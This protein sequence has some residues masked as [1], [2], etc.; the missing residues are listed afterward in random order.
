MVVCGQVI[1]VGC[2][3]VQGDKFDEGMVLKIG[4]QG[5]VCLCCGDGFMLVFG[6]NLSLIIEKYEVGF[7]DKC[8][9]VK[10][11]LESGLLGQKV[12]V[13]IV[14]FWEV[15]MFIVVMVVCGIE[16]IVEINSE[17]QI[18][19]NVQFGQVDVEVLLVFMCV[20][21]LCKFSCV[22][23]DSLKVG[24]KCNQFMGCIELL[25]WSVEWIKSIQDCLS[26]D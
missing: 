4:V 23:L 7:D 24:M 11:L 18:E 25:V 8:I 15:C 22:L 9:V 21:Y 17:Q 12:V 1:V 19:V 6:D 13:F 20:L 26:F 14:G 16:F 5:W 2:V 10:L 3:F